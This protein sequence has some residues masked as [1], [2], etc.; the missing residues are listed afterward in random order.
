LR[1]CSRPTP[2]SRFK[3][4]PPP[5]FLLSKYSNDGQA[6][7]RTLREDLSAKDR[8]LG[9]A[10]DEAKRAYEAMRQ[11]ERRLASKFQLVLNSKKSKIVELTAAIE[12][13]GA[14]QGLTFL[15]LDR[16]PLMVFYPI[17]IKLNTWSYFI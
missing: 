17:L 11:N 13:G 3:I 1:A 8:Q 2:P 4:N 12:A 5:P 14:F 16:I 7:I 15:F 9:V 10:V 6:S